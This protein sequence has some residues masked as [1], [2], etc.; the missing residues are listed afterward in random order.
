MKKV[1]VYCGPSLSRDEIIG[2][3]GERAEI[4]PPIRR[5]D[6]NE[7]SITNIIAIVDGVFGGILAIS[8]REI[9]D[10]L[11]RGGVVYGSSSMGALRAVELESFGMKGYGRIFESFKNGEA[12]S[13][14]D[15][16]LAFTK[17]EYK[18]ISEP[19]IHFRF[20]SKS[21]IANDIVGEEV[22]RLIESTA[23]GIYYPLLTFETVF[24]VLKDEIGKD[25]LNK[26]I[27][28]YRKKPETFNIKKMDAIGLLA[29]I[30]MKYFSE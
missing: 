6:L 22:A 29:H 30:K 15:V 25:D 12:Y 10:Y 8:P 18:Q 16:A 19:L 9:K 14:A 4:K 1:I 28:Y 17:N 20:F 26:I 2:I 11:E 5:G 24:S 27:H 3:L 21:L 23:E 13:D 7:Q